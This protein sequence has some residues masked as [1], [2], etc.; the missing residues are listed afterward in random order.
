MR[1]SPEMPGDGI[2][3]ITPR[4]IFCSFLCTLHTPVHISRRIANLSL[5]PVVLLLLA[6]VVIGS[7]FAGLFATHIT[8]SPPIFL[9]EFIVL[10]RIKLRPDLIFAVLY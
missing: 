10:H 3:R 8:V 1:R 5:I 9:L 6:T 7:I 4:N 2:T